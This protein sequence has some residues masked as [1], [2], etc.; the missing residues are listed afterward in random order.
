MHHHRLLLRIGLYEVSYMSE[1]ELIS[2][3]I[4]TWLFVKGILDTFGVSNIIALYVA[5]DVLVKLFEIMGAA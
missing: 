2:I 4:L 3:F 5:W 1:V